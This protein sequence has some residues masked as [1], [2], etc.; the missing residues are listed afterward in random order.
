LFIRAGLA[1]EGAV[2][3]AVDFLAGDFFAV[4]EEVFLLTTEVL[5]LSAFVVAFLLAGFL[6]AGLL[7]VVIFFAGAGT[8]FL[9][10]P[11]LPGAAPLFSVPALGEVAFFAAGF[12]F[13][14]VMSISS[15]FHG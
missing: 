10:L 11:D 9:M 13:V 8:V 4:A 15:M 3:F 6:A 14:S 5:G 1:L 7:A 2:L 12:N